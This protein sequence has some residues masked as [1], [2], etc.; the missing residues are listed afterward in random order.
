[1][2]NRHCGD[3]HDMGHV[4]TNSVSSETQEGQPRVTRERGPSQR[5]SDQLRADARWSTM[6]LRQIGPPTLR[7]DWCR[8]EVDA[9]FAGRVIRCDCGQR[10]SVPA[11]IRVRC[12]RCSFSHWVRSRELQVE[13]L[14]ASC[15]QPLVIEDVVLSPLRR[16]RAQQ[17]SAAASPGSH[18]NAGW[19]MLLLGMALL[20]AFMLFSML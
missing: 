3:E 2:T 9:D 10:L 15:G 6:P 19:T 11:R 16:H 12:G 20:A 1:M 8:D 5:P 17:F 4:E 18:G 14:C 7:C 13:R